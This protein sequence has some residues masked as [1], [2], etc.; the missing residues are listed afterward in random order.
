MLKS[1]ALLTIATFAPYKQT[2][3]NHNP[4]ILIYFNIFSPISLVWNFWDHCNMYY[5]S[6]VLFP[7]PY[8]TIFIDPLLILILIQLHN[9]ESNPIW[10][11]FMLC[12]CFLPAI[13]YYVLLCIC[14]CISRILCIHVHI[15]IPSGWPLCQCHN[16][17]LMEVSLAHYIETK[18]MWK[19]WLY[20]MWLNK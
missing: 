9:P 15:D 17:V 3:N 20:D 4:D 19:L 1:P 14:T 11:D 13:Y 5:I 16:F 18:C 10:C 2:V 7:S 12:I 8:K 6:H